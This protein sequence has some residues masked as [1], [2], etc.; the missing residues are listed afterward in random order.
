[1]ELYAQGAGHQDGKQKRDFILDKMIPELLG[2]KFTTL[3]MKRKIEALD[4]EH[5]EVAI[6]NIM[7]NKMDRDNML[8]AMKDPNSLFSQLHKI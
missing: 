5:W 2:E 4:L 3:E 6:T 1:M 7:K 8:K